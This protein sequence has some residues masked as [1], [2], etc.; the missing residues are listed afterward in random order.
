MKHPRR[1][2]G[3]ERVHFVRHA[4]DQPQLRPWQLQFGKGLQEIM[5]A[6]TKSNTPTIYYDPD[7]V[8]L[9]G[10]RMKMS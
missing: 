1:D 4:P 8:I 2:F 9:F 10:C 6:F 5:D 3:E 7:N